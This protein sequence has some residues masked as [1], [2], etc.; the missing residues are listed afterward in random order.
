MDPPGAVRQP[1]AGPAARSE[2]RRRTTTTLRALLAHRG[3][4]LEP[5]AT[6]PTQAEDAYA[7]ARHVSVDRQGGRSCSIEQQR[8]DRVPLAPAVVSTWEESG[9]KSAEELHDSSNRSRES[10][11]LAP[12]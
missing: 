11:S 9:E 10:P 7:V 4:H 12:E 1:A 8:H 3:A 6:T 2:A 5:R